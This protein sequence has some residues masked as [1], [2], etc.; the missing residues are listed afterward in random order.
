MKRLAPLGGGSPEDFGAVLP[1][2]KNVKGFPVEILVDRKG[3]VRSARNGY[4]FKKKW[5]ERLRQDIE[6]LLGETTD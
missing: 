5:A 4:G 3:R 6:S 2:V 1:A